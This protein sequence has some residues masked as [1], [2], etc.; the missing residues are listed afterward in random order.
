VG[1]VERTGRVQRRRRVRE[2]PFERARVL[3]S[4]RP[5][6]EAQLGRQPSD[7]RR[8]APGQAWPQPELDRAA[9]DQAAGVTGRAVQQEVG[10]GRP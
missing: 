5:P 7:L 3:E 2:R 10:R 1:L 9:R 6:F 4:E 8:V